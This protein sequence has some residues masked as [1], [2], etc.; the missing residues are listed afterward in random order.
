MSA[1]NLVHVLNML[2]RAYTRRFGA[3]GASYTDLKIT[4]F[5]LTQRKSQRLQPR[6][7]LTIKKSGILG[8]VH[9]LN[10]SR[11]AVRET[12]DVRARAPRAAAARA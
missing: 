1:P 4:V 5:R 8:A 2:A 9:F 10:P 6:A 12:D 7:R 11:R 3:I